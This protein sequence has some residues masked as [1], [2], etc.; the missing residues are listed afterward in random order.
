MISKEE[1][2][3]R[4]RQ[5]LRR[6]C[7]DRTRGNCFKL[8]ENRFRFGIRKKSFTTREVRQ[9]NSMPRDA[10]VGLIPGN[11]QGKAG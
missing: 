1:L 2:E 5:T 3:E 10:V 7:G 8:K 9:W 6:V 11:F 4:K